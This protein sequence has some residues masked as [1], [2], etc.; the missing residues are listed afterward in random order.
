MKTQRARLTDQVVIVTGA[1]S[2]I[3]RATAL[4]FARDGAVVVATARSAEGRAETVR[5]IREAG[6]TSLDLGVDVCDPS[7]VE[8]LVA[9]ALQLFGRIDVLVASA[10]SGGSRAAARRIPY[11][12]S[13]LPTE[14]WDEVIDTNLKGVFLCNRAVLPSMIKNGSGT[15]VNISSARGAFRGLP[16]AAAYSASKHGL[17]GLSEA[18]AEEVH[19]MGIRVHVVSPDVTDTPMLQLSG[20][21]APQGLLDPNM[22]GRF[23]VDI[24][25]TPQDTLWYHHSLSP[26]AATPP[27]EEV[28]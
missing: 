11:A 21:L 4:A 20:D 14:E 6:G 9:R 2:G 19:A 22:V 25:T 12:V 17:M 8:S 10:G 3:G 24:V 26:F 23:I 28:F 1:S 16:Y 27:T 7:S 13:Q 5:R 15:I 18:L